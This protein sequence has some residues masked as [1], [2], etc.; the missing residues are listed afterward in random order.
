[1][2]GECKRISIP[3][4]LNYDPVLKECL[5]C[6]SGFMLEPI[7]KNFC[8]RCDGAGPL[9]TACRKA[10]ANETAIA[11]NGIMCTACALQF[12]LDEQKNTCEKCVDHCAFCG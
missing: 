10:D 4:C 7:K 9:C 3:D 8:V 1:M 12:S 11:P 6:R 5:Y 2:S